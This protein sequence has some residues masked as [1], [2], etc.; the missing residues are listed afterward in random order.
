MSAK[1]YCREN[2]LVSG[3]AGPM[4]CLFSKPKRV[5]SR[6]F[7]LG[8]MVFTILFFEC[9]ALYRTHQTLVIVDRLQWVA[10]RRLTEVVV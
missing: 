1:C 7:V 3:F 9:F 5:S 4:K 8:Y 6:A 10:D 2:T